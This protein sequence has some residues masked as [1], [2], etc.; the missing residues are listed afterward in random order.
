MSQSIEIAENHRSG[1]TVMTSRLSL[2]W[3]LVAL[4]SL[5][6]G[7]L[8]AGPE[9]CLSRQSNAEVAAC[10]N[11]FGPNS[12]STRARSGKP[13]DP[14]GSRS[15]QASVAVEP[16]AVLVARGGKPAPAPEPQGPKFDVDREVLTNTI[17]AGTVGG[18]LLVLAAFGIW[19]WRSTL[20]RSCPWCAAR[21]SR[22]VRS[23]PRC[24]RA[25]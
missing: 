23:C 15:V 18:T 2:G 8:I 19:R 17:I 20:K 9:E 3:T 24:F 11:Q 16:R 7:R 10:A 22:T 13:S 4:L 14:S 25:I 1:A 5:A 12:S 21:I 6:P